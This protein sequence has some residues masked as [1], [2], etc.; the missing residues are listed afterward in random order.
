MVGNQYAFSEQSSLR[1]T[2]GFVIGHN[3]VG[4]FRRRAL[5]A[6]RKRQA[7]SRMGLAHTCLPVAYSS[8]NP[9]PPDLTVSIV[10]HGQGELVAALLADIGPHV[11]TPLRVILT[12]NLP[13]PE[14]AWAKHSHPFEIEVIRNPVRNGFGANHNA[15]LALARGELFCVLNPDIRLRSD[16]FPVLVAALADRRTGVA[17]PLVTNPDLAPEDHAREFPSLFALAAKALGGRPRTPPPQGGTM[18]HPDWVA[19][20]FML[21]RTGTLR[22]VGGFD[23]RYFLY[24]EDV[25]LCARMCERGLEVSVCPAASVIHAARRESRANPR[26]AL[27]HLRSA[28]RFLVSQPRIAL[29][30]GRKR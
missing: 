6:A 26:Y 29:G 25:D 2:K 7:P 18:Y 19:G 1:K 5:H 8:H 23:E 13:E 15:A 28:L 30:L 27:W 12:I 16:P 9:M 24:Y 11:A 17:A 10:S 3:E 22:S 4:K 20:M 14:E 21:L